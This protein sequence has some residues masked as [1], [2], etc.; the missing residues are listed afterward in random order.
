MRGRCFIEV[1]LFTVRAAVDASLDST[2]WDHRVA[3]PHAQDAIHASE[4]D[5]STYFSSVEQ[6][7]FRTI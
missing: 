2:A 5:F 3:L 7:F 6:T 1:T 4:R